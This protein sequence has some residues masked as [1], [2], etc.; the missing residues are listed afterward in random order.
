MDDEDGEKR[1]RFF[2][3][4]KRRRERQLKEKKKRLDGSDSEGKEDSEDGGEETQ[5]GAYDSLIHLGSTSRAPLTQTKRTPETEQIERELNKIEL[6]NPNTSPQY[7]A[8]LKKTGS[9]ESQE[10]TKEDRSSLLTHDDYLIELDFT[11]EQEDD[12]L[13]EISHM[14]ANSLTSC[15]NVGVDGAS[16]DTPDQ[17]VNQEE[18]PANTTSSVTQH[19]TITEVK[20]EPNKEE[21]LVKEE[22]GTK[23]QVITAEFYRKFIEASTAHGKPPLNPKD[24]RRLYQDINGKFR[25]GLGTLQNLDQ[26]LPI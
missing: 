14:Q 19:E 13:E 2:E 16:S 25:Q 24:E 17:S 22:P 15:F 8:N 6:N 9:I 1:A 11:S 10:N 18:A 26:H 4:K 3:D 5:L 12:S 21:V 7:Q 23:S 20:S